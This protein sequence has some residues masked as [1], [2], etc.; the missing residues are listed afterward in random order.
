MPG[1]SPSPARLHAA[2]AAPCPGVPASFPVAAT[3]PAVTVGPGLGAQVNGVN[4]VGTDVVTVLAADG[5]FD[6]VPLRAIA[7]DGSSLIVAL[8]AIPGGIDID[9]G[10]G[11]DIRVGDL[12]MLSRNGIST[13]L[14]VS[15]VNGAARL[16]RS[17]PAT[18]S[19]STSSTR[20]TTI[21]PLPR[22]RDHQPGHLRR[23]RADRVGNNPN[24]TPR[25]A[26]TRASRIR[27]FDLRRPHRIPRMQATRVC[28]G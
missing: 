14:Y 9:D 13:L 4:G 10:G 17:P 27:M 16:S 25:V 11:D 6:N 19:G 3:I 23:R 24:G 22:W 20:L 18:R 21:R 8:P 2:A 7:A 5:T 15:G 26:A 12:I 1:R 28:C